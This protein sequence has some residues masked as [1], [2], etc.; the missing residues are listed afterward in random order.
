MD[1]LGNRRR[2][3]IVFETDRHTVVGDVTLPAEGY[4]ARFSDAINR[5]EVAF[6]PLVDV[7]ISPL[8]GGAAEKHDFVVLAKAHIRLAHSLGERSV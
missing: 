1:S 2:E 5:P 8:D 6:I 7:E 3:R 4:Q